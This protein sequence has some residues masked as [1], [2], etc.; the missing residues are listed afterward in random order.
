MHA[1]MDGV[2]APSPPDAQL[3]THAWKVDGGSLL[4]SCSVRWMCWFTCWATRK[5]SLSPLC[6]ACG[7]GCS[8]YGA[9]ALAGVRIEMI[10]DI[11]LLACSGQ[12]GARPAL[13]LGPALSAPPHFL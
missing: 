4:M 2:L 9:E 10:S 11:A 6:F 3:S 13:A 12:L 5:S 7:C 8:W 1:H